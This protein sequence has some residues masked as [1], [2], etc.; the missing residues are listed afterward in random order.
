MT[1]K[2]KN[3]C[4]LAA[5]LL[6]YT[7]AARGQEIAGNP[8]REE[9][10]F[11]ENSKAGIRLAGTLTLPDA[12]G[13]FPAVVLVSG[14]GAQNRD[15]ELMGHKP[16]RVIADHLT[17]AGIAVLRYDDRGTAAS[18]GDFSK[19]TTADL[20][21]DAEAALRY[22]GTRKELDASMIG[23]AGHS[24]GG[25]IAPLVA[26]QHPG[27]VAFIILLAAAGVRGDSLL[28]LQSG[29]IQRAYRVDEQRV[30]RALNINRSIYKLVSGDAAPDALRSALEREITSDMTGGVPPDAFIDA[31]I[32]QLS[33]PWL[34]Y[35][36]SYDPAP[37]L[38]K[39]SCPV[40]VLNGEKDLQVPAEI[41]PGA[42][43]E[44]LAR[45]GNK[46][47]RVRIFPR[48]NHLFQECL[49]GV[50][51]EYPTLERTFVPEVLNEIVPWIKSLP[52]PNM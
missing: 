41:N 29:A 26:A 9:E 15:E 13:R 52:T 2:F 5:A 43:R 22:L 24:E 4:R 27:Y 35:F 16:F 33:T 1:R 19:A 38:E 45:G 40:L 50:P 37:T 23:L 49:T 48:L 30:Q 42:I 3:V 20:A 8:Y 18:E 31:Q 10:V 11:F 6:F 36:L 44:A 32:K 39:V 14:S 47:V 12:E 46:N 51:A 17:R 34:K 7:V 25:V 21:T 28:L